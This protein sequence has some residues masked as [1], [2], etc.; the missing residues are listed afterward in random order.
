MPDLLVRL[1]DLPHSDAEDRLAAEGISIRRAIAPERQVVLDWIAA[2][3]TPLWVSEAAVGLSSVPATVWIAVSDDG[4]LGFACA[5]TSAR[6]FFGPTGVDEAWRG[7]GIGE[8]L[9][10]TTLRAMRE[11]G[12]AYAVI[13]DAGPIDFY[14]KRL[15]ALEIPKSEPGHYAGMLRPPRPQ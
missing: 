9:L 15:D 6:G 7:R 4:P 5:D 10:M 2:R 12:Y 3:F 14:R 11:M 1:Y 8:A 13:G